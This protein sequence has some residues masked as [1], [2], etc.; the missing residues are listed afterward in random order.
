[1]LQKL[2][3]IFAFCIWDARS[4]FF[5][6]VRDSLGVKPIYY[7][8]SENLFAFASEL[9]SLNSL[10]INPAEI[11]YDSIKQYISYLWCPGDGTPNKLIKKLNP[12]E[13]LIVKNGQI[14]KKW[15]WYKL[16]IFRKL[17]TNIRKSHAINGVTNLLRRA[18]HN[19]M[20]SDVPVG[21][22]LSG[23]LDSS[24]VVN[25]ARELN[26]DIRCFSI[27]TL[28]RQDPGFVD[29]LPY[30]KEVAKHLDVSLD[31]VSVDYTSIVDDLQ[32]MII[33]LG[34]PIADPAALN[35]L[36]ISKEAKKQGIKVLLSGAGGDDLFTGY[37]RHKAIAFQQ[38]LNWIPNSFFEKLESIINKQNI[39]RAFIRRISKLLSGSNLNANDKLINYFKWTN[40]LT[41]KTLLTD[42]FTRMLTENKP[43]IQMLDFLSPLPDNIS[44]LESMLALEQ[45]FFLGDHNL[46]YTD[47]MSM[48]AGVEVRVPFL[49]NDLLDYVTQIPMKYKQRGVSGKWVLKKAMESYL[50]KKI[51]YRPKA[52][53]GMP[54]RS[55]VKNE[56]HEF[57][58]DLLSYDSLN[59]RGFF[60]PIAV[61]NLIKD[62]SI[63]KI[64]ASYTILSLLCIEI[65]CREY[66]DKLDLQIAV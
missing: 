46:N 54:V 3:G 31:I 5:F 50:P 56:L 63:G 23:G 58:C 18:V 19:Q 22:F 40:D 32:K 26:P 12:G 9:N 44:P 17:N 38:Y 51:I 48:A 39:N 41:L 1:M 66:L 27:E 33:Q 15:Q 52:G 28:G 21:A 34:E 62:N 20:I 25:F 55:W 30:A 61:H 13:A 6:I 64:D 36:Y 10:I 14:Q 4:Q 2:N 24:S 59:Q 8:S 53:F 11:D 43:G 29:D 35:V 42:D 16:P 60:S 65:W 47:K 57:I 37:R 45:R 7:H 49:D